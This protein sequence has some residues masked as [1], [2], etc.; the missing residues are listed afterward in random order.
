[1]IAAVANYN[2]L[3]DT[4]FLENLHVAA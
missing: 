4:N 1:V 3:L 2:E